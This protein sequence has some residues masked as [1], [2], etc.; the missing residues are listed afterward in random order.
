MA[1]LERAIAIAAAAHAGQ[2]DKGGEPYILHPLRVMLRMQ[3]TPER[4]VAVLHDVVE[5]SDM[6]LEILGAEGFSQEVLAAVDALTKRRGESRSEAARRAK[7]DRIALAVKLADNA[8]NM[9]LSRIAAPTERDYV[10]LEEYKVVRA[11]LLGT[12]E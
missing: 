2:V 9:D 7:K 4:I 5:D 6:T 10:R 8:E 12:A 11:I 1:T 3:S